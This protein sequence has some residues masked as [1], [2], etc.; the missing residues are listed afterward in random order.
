MIL[1]SDPK[2][3]NAAWE[4][5]FTPKPPL[6]VGNLESKGSWQGYA[7]YQTAKEQQHLY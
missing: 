3:L 5:A 1:S 2:A 7:Q 4:E 6:F